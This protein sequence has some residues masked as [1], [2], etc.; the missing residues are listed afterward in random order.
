MTREEACLAHGGDEMRQEDVFWR[1]L[2]EVRM[3]RLVQL[4]DQRTPVRFHLPHPLS[5]HEGLCIVD[6]YFSL[7]LSL[8][9]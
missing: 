7:S 9:G 4:S 8:R 3:P 5:Q 1:E 6:I 2:C